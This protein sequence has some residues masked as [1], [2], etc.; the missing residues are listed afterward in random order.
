M[1]V[2]RIS[3]EELKEMMDSGEK[4]AILDIRNKFDYM[5]SDKKIPGSIR[6][7]VNALLQR[8]EELDPEVLTV[9]YC[10]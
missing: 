10:T 5:N 9:A 1:E 6:M 8:I 7:H 2:K 3:A 4:V